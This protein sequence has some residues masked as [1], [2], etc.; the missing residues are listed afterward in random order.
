MRIVWCWEAWCGE[1]AAVGTDKNLQA[2]AR[3]LQSD[4]DARVVRRVFAESRGPATVADA[5][6]QQRALRDV[7]L[8]RG[9]EIV[10]F[11]IGYTS[12]SVRKGGFATMG[13]PPS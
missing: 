11:K 12:P 2:L 4:M 8:A 5:Y 10:G 9:E 1:M 7:R 13:T 3:E 6:A